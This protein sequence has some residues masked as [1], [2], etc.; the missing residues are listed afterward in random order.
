MKEEKKHTHKFLARNPGKT[1]EIEKDT[2]PW[3]SMREYKPK[4]YNLE[5][6]KDRGIKKAL[7]T[8]SDQED[9]G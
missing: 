2:Q 4:H 1:P 7:S 5:E 6:M 9:L 3:T 8:A